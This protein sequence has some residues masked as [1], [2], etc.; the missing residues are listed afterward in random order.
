[1]STK[2][3]SRLPNATQVRKSHTPVPLRPHE[4]PFTAE[5]RD[6]V[7]ILFGGL[8]WKHE[9]LIQ[10]HCVKVATV[11]RFVDGKG[12]INRMS[13]QNWHNRRY[14]LPN[15]PTDQRSGASGLNVQVQPETSS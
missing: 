7:T 4:L 5:E 1:M 10:G 15:F 13:R 2:T 9:R 6:S 11:A 3:Q 8:T 12:V 14:L